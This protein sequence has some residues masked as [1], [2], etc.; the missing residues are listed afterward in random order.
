FHELEGD[1]DAVDG[2]VE[3]VDRR[4]PGPQHGARSERIGP[5]SAKRMPVGNAEAE[6]VLHRL[7]FDHRG[8]V[9]MAK[10]QRVLRIGTFVADLRNLGKS[11]HRSESLCG[12]AGIRSW[13]YAFCA[14]VGAA[15]RGPSCHI[16]ARLATVR[17]GMALARHWLRRGP[18]R[19]AKGFAA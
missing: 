9:V 10:R 13:Q 18:E 8:F 3:R 14:A 12:D 6:M 16:S 1:V 15:P 7:A 2:V 19:R 17:K 4:F 5:R 11:S